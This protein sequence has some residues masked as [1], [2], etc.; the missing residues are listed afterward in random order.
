MHTNMKLL[1]GSYL[2]TK[3]NKRFTNENEIIQSLL[4][5]I[6]KFNILNI[7]KFKRNMIP[8]NENKKIRSL[9][10]KFKAAQVIQNIKRYIKNQNETLIRNQWVRAVMRYIQRLPTLHDGYYVIVLHAYERSLGPFTLKMESACLSE[11][12]APT[13]PTK[14][15]HN[16]EHCNINFQCR[17]NLIC[18]IQLTCLF[19][20]KL[21]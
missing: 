1:S 3:R 12:L 16:P 2:Y 7:L 13:Y 9:P 6:L 18:S 11:T 21:N 19:L 20:Y 4:F 5:N 14:R 10:F 8:T 15:C 17:N